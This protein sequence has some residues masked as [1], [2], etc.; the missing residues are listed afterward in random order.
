MGYTT[1]FSGRFVTD[2]PLPSTLV[3]K[4]QKLAE[5]RHGGPCN[6]YDGYPGFWCQWVPSDDGMGIEWDGGEKF[7]SYDKWLQLIIDRYLTPA[8]ISL[9]GKVLFRGE[10]ISDVGYLIAE[11]GRVRMQM[12]VPAE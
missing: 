4:L 7:Y 9:S 11:A 5:D 3:S 6:V 12:L 1:E 10:E 8:G 2:K